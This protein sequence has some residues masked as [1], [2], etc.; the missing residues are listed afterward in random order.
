MMSLS[1]GDGTKCNNVNFPPY[2][3]SYFSDIWTK[4][5]KD[6]GISDGQSE[7]TFPENYGVKER[8]AFYKSVSY[9]GWGG[10]SGHD[11]PLIA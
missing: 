11:A 6:R 10:A 1:P 4:Y 2:D 8:D 9:G 5:L 3:R 7:P